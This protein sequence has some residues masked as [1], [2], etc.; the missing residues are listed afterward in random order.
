MV[1]YQ[2]K[3]IYHKP[4]L[5]KNDPRNQKE[6]NYIVKEKTENESTYLSI[7]CESIESQNT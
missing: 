4:F 6:E 5:T 7:V 1:I 2:G 3:Y